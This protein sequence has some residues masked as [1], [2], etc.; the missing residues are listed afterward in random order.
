MISRFG[1]SGTWDYQELQP[2]STRST[3]TPPLLRE[4]AGRF[5]GPWKAH[6]T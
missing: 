2:D 5:C 3:S 1:W 6:W 4:S